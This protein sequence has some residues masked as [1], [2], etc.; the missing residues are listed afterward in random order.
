MR[1]ILYFI[2]LKVFMKYTFT[3]DIEKQL[4]IKK[5]LN[6]KFIGIKQKTNKKKVC[7]ICF[8]SYKL[9]QQLLCGHCFHNKCINKWLLTHNSCPICRN[10]I[11][12]KLQPEN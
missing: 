6:I 11:Q 3:F 4:R 10:N 7:D 8:K 1:K 2:V 12:I 5:N 9:E